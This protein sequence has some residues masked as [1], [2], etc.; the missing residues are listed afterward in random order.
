MPHTTPPVFRFAPSPNGAL[1]LGHACSA[2]INQKMA[3][4]ASGNL[5]L[6]I[7]DIDTTRCTLELETAMLDDLHWLGI[8][9]TREPRRQSQHF[10]DYAVSL[11]KL[12]QAE[13]I[14][15]AFMSRAEIQNAV[16]GKTDWPRDPDG[17][18]HYPG[19]ERS[20]SDEQRENMIANRPNHAWRLDMHKAL[21]RVDR[22]LSWTEH[23]SG[24]GDRKVITDP[25]IWGDVVLARSDTPTSYHLSVVLDD[26][27]QGITHV[28]RG[29]DLYH[30]TSIHRLL[31]E[32]LALP[33]PLYHHHRLIL[34]QDGKKLSKSSNDT[35]LRSLRKAGYSPADI[36]RMVGL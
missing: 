32:L 2:L 15:P 35:S 24:M 34:A 4:E 13:L 30:A 23:K 8:E 26:A 18:P 11:D 28:V 36:Q 17:Q 27:L 6:R 29:K 25:S 16:E 12:R 10:D 14:Y 22:R 9:W 21:D 1:H 5:L 33:E 3:Q 31:Q 7:E 20:W 19:G